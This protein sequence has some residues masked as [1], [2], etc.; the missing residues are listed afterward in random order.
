[1]KVDIVNL[2]TQT[3]SNLY[4]SSMK[5]IKNTPNFTGAKILSNDKI[6]NELMNLLHHKKAIE[7]MKSFEWLKGEIG[8]ILLTAVGTGLVAPIFIGFN[9]FVSAPKGATEKEKKD[10]ENT[11]Q[12]TAMRQPVSAALAILFQ[13]GVQKYIDKGLDAVFNNPKRSKKVF[14][15]VDRQ[16]INT[17]TYIKDKVKKKLLEEEKLQKPSY[18]KSLFNSNLMKKRNEYEARFKQEVDA[19]K[20]AQLQTVVDDLK[21]DHVIHVGKTRTLDHKTTA[22]LI[23]K[24]IKSYIGD[25]DKLKKAKSPGRILF[26]RDRA[27]LLYKNQ[28]HLKEIFKEVPIEES[29]I[30]LKNYLEA[31]YQVPSDETK[32]ATCKDE[33]N[34]VNKKVSEA[35]NALIEKE[36]NKDV[37]DLLKEVMDRPEDL[38]AHRIERTLKRIDSINEISKSYENGFTPIDYEKTLKKRNHILSDLIVDFEDAEIKDVKNADEKVIEQAIN[39]IKKVCQFDEKNAVLKSILENTDTFDSDG[40]KLTDKIYK[41]I[42]KAYKKMVEN[43]YKGWNQLTKVGVGVFITLPITCTALN[44]VYPRFMEIFFPK[45]AGVKKNNAPQNVQQQGGDK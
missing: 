9:P 11:K 19:M 1:M 23:N 30:A 37:K 3:G 14:I 33:L 35:I 36:S 6:E 34:K 5:K 38:R 39:K 27:E 12:Y 7:F 15:N 24:Q 16:V 31:M 2:N 17:D 10:V 8:G 4:N 29:K 26:Y 40:E 13:A 42:A 41:D 45:L 22:E 20:E 18:I 28:E 43:H 44:W 32:K 25:V 21:K